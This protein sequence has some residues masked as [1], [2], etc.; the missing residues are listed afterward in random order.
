[1][2]RPPREPVAYSDGNVSI[3]D[4]EEQ[5][6]VGLQR[7]FHSVGLKA[8]GFES[9][10]AF[11]DQDPRTGPHCLVVDVRMPSM[12]GLDLQLELARRADPTPVILITGHADVPMTVRAMKAG[13]LDFLT[14]PF[15]DQDVLDAV[16]RGLDLDDRRR[17]IEAAFTDI[18]ARYATLTDRE[19]TVMRHVL[20]GRL[21]KQTAADLDI[22]EITVKAHRASLMRK[23]HAGSLI[24]LAGFSEALV[25]ELEAPPR[26]GS[27]TG[28]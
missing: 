12:S 5:V 8:Q 1:M 11:L 4:D 17:Q 10:H 22:S 27:R 21:N 24:Q 19:K 20:A 7:L 16:N 9:A 6:R 26:T 25:A 18:R 15:R 23:M 14:K 28:R 2:S 3:I 13:A